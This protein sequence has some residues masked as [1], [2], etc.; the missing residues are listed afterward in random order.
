[1]L[2][3]QEL[4]G[5]GVRL[6]AFVPDAGTIES[7]DDKR[8]SVTRAFLIPPSADQGKTLDLRTFVHGEDFTAEKS[9]QPRSLGH[10]PH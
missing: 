10:V 3:P 1:M 5:D 4:F 6:Y 9:S 8:V 2:P 7:T